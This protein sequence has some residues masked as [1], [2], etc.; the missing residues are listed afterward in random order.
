M[1]K[2]LIFLSFLVI[3][4]AFTSCKKD[5]EKITMLKSITANVLSPLT[6]NSFVL[7]RDSAAKNFQTF[8]WTTIDYG[9]ATPI[10]YTVQVDRKKNK[11]SAPFDVVTVSNL[12]KGSINVGDFNKILLNMG[13]AT[14]VADT[15]VFRVKA[16]INSK[17]TPVYSNPDTALVTPY[18]TV[19][20]PI[21]M[22]G[23]ATGGWGWDLYT[24]KELR[25]TAPNIYETI[26][27]FTNANTFRFF[28]QTFW[29]PTSWNYP[30][31]TGGVNPLCE[32]A[33]D[34]DL[35]FRFIGT[36]G[37]YK[38]TVNMST[39]KVEMVSQP[40][41]VLYMTGAALGGWNWSTDYVQL[42]WMSNG[43]YQARTDF[44]VETFRFFAQADWGPTSYNYPYFAG[45]T[46]SNMFVNANDGDKNFKFV[47]TPGTYTLNVN[48]L[49]KII[50]MVAK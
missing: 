13:I 19:F 33:A 36:S 44:V 32:N 6:S 2:I 11:F 10:S 29:N 45:G 43:I 34:G 27:Y 26:A 28:K 1:K 12:L 18:A 46:I 15:L 7:N 49:D 23:A 37:Y 50:T 25:S 8:N 48:F 40:D 30:Y 47:G 16:V 39:K 31:F 14:D 20:P 5:L 4:S 38:I 17:V 35:N 41:Q 42:T 3:A 9:F 24:Y 21:Y 22:D